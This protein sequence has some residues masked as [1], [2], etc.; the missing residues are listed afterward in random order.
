MA[1]IIKTV[2]PIDSISGMIGSRESNLCG[3]AFIANIRKKGGQKHKGKPH[4]YF[5]V[6]TRSTAP[7]ELTEAILARRTKFGAVVRSTYA[8]M[9]DPAQAAQDMVNFQNQSKY[10]TMYSYIFNLEWNAYTA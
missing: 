4:Q 8:R 10:V 7:T 1:K 9:A 6:L 5:S 2:A 3:K